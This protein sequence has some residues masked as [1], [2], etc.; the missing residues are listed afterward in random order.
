[1]RS[2]Y[3]AF[4]RDEMDY[5]QNSLVEE[6]RAEFKA[7][8][9]SFPRLNIFSWWLYLTGACLAVT[10]LFTGGGPPDTGV[11]SLSGRKADSQSPGCDEIS[12]RERMS[13]L[14]PQAK[15]KARRG[16]SPEHHRRLPRRH[17]V[18]PQA[19]R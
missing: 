5:L 3:T 10:S 9:V 12:Y 8:D 17:T 1:M 2:R 14:A 15:T 16:R 13:T 19:A 11:Q 7:E 6:H 18:R 4:C